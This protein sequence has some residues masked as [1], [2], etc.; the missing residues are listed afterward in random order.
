MISSG[1]DYSCAERLEQVGTGD[2][3]CD[4]K[5][6]SDFAGLDSSRPIGTRKLERQPRDWA[7]EIDNIIK[8]AVHKAPRSRRGHVT[9]RSQ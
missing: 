9:P 5:Q 2:A 6:R 3:Y 7:H 8:R 1:T 4:D